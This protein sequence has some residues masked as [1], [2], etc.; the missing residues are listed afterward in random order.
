VSESLSLVIATY[1]RARLLDECL[2]AV[3]RQPFSDGD[4]ILVADNASTDGTASVVAA[5][6]VAGGPRVRYLHVAQ[7]GKSF[8]LQAAVASA[9]GSLLA[10][11]DDDVLVDDG[12]LA[13]IR[14]AMAD[15]QV[16]LA[17]GPVLPRWER[18]APRWLAI[19]NGPFN[20][21]AAP[22]ALL[23]YGDR[24]GELGPRTLLGANMVIRRD[25]LEAIGG[26]A[27]HLGKLRGTLLSG[28]D[29]DLCAR[30][31]DRG[32]STR[33][34]PDAIVRH[35]VPAARMRLGY[36]A[37]WFYWSG[38]THAVM[39]G[40][41]SVGRRLLGLPTWLVRRGAG[42]PVRV[43]RAAGRGAPADLVDVLADLA[44]VAGYAAVCWRV[45]TL[46]SPALPAVQEQVTCPSRPS[47]S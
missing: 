1:N 4:E 45:V 24:P 39:D 20:R 33:Y 22:I 46:N 40:G 27:T 28:E 2:S 36:Y 29:A 17:G 18:P 35:W 16:V 5:H 13:A 38:I 32:W 15:P 9:R 37:T 14:A 26:F 31:A 19:G 25:A 8:A 43:A 10:F 44:F 47:L 11:L 21:L 41:A 42:I 30:V 6:Q 12:W 3:R 23:H 7:P 34:A